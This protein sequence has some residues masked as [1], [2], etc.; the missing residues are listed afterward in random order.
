MIPPFVKKFDFRGIYNHDL[1]DSDAFHL[2][3]A[4]AK[5][6]EIKKVLIGWDTRVSSRNLALSFIQALEGKNIEICYIDTCSIDFITAS[7]NASD[8]DFSV[9]FTGSHNPWNWTGLL[10]H[11]KG[12]ESIS[13]DLVKK[14]IEKYYESKSIEFEKGNI[15]LSQFKNYTDKAESIISEKIRTLIPVEKIKDMK[16][17]VDIG[18]GSGFKSLAILEKILP[19][20]LF[21][22][23]NDAHV[24]DDK[25]PHTA[26]PSNI[27]NM[28]DLMGAVKNEEFSCG[29]AFDSDA[30]RV[31]AIDENGDY[32][33]GS[34]LGS[35][36]VQVFA[37][38][39]NDLKIGYAV[40][41]G[42]SVYNAVGQINQEE[43]RSLSA[44]PIPVGRSVV[45]EM[46]HAGKIDFGVENVGHFYTKEFFG[47]DSGI[48]SIVIILYWMSRYGE[49][50]KIKTKYLEGARDQIFS[51]ASSGDKSDEL[52]EKIRAHFSTLANKKIEVDGIR[53]E[54]FKDDKMFAWCAVRKSGYEEIYKYYFGSIDELEFKAMEVIFQ[55]A[56]P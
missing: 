28:R 8:F 16:V 53:Y 38:L 26:D 21:H 45:R 56:L 3:I 7:A 24:Y 13:G 31:L 43:A 14:L 2:G 47:T 25:A 27:K 55:S 52:M 15:D 54:F 37:E 18:N 41:C 33:E 35:A 5:V 34:V 9:M 39:F 51:P 10:M 44:A 17:A 4:I 49:L 48:F 1:Y 30:D 23:I 11:T 36:H 42:P 46:V 6:V 22:H 40:D 19:Q 12:G 50:S 29:F 20:V 32:L